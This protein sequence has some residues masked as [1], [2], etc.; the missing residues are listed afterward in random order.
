MEKIRSNIFVETV[1]PGVNVGCVVTG[2]GSI[3][4]D[5]PW[6]PAEA[7]RWRAR[8][9]SLD[10]EPVR[11][12]V[13]TNGQQERVLGT[14]YLIRPQQPPLIGLPPPPAPEHNQ[15]L[16]KGTVVA[17]KQAWEQVQSLC[18]N[19]FKQSMIDFL[20]DRDP[21][22]VDLEV[23]LPQITLDERIKL[24]AGDEVV[25]L[26]AASRG[27]L[28]VWLAEQRVLFTGDTIV[29]GTHP[30]LTITDTEEWLG[31]LERLRQEEQF[32]D[33]VIVP[34][35][36]ALCDVSAAEPLTSYLSMAR[37]S[38]LKIYRTGRSKADLNAVAAD[39]MPLYPVANGQR[40]RVQRQIKQ[41]LDELYDACK[42]AD[43]ANSE[44]P[45]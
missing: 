7:Q 40:E 36:G 11:V 9:R 43:A 12:V 15:D 42:A 13:Y 34:G 24:F 4:I 10:G 39:L 3:C 41:G 22:V 44:A 2:Q 38:T 27:M 8:I 23:I 18:S 37:E 33:A 45:G 17:H 28:W 16:G 30:P 19:N 31:A 1:Y 5:T 21:D 29:V 26:L 32:Q 6:L 25:T 14:Q 20:A 35:R